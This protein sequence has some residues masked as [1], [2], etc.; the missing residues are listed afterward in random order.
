AIYRVYHV[1]QTAASP[2]KH[3]SWV[4][5]T[6]QGISDVV[7]GGSAVETLD[8]IIEDALARRASDIH[9]E[10]SEAGLLVRF[11]LDA[12]FAATPHIPRETT[13]PLLSRLKVMAGLDI[14][15]RMR[16]QD[17]RASVVFEGGSVDLRIS[18]LP[19]GSA[20]E[21]AVIRLLNSSATNAD[22]GNIGFTSGER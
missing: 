1:S 12:G 17:G 3:L 13:G 5:A 2:N 4:R 20:G 8:G 6:P 15:D 21:K 19:L 10:P 14:A 18:T 7:G 11:R 9:I 16:P 22:L